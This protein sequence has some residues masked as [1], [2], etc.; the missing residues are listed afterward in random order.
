MR[1]YGQTASP[2]PAAVADPSPAALA[3]L[4]AGAVVAAALAIR[5]ALVARLCGL[6]PLPLHRRLLA[7]L[8][9]RS[10]R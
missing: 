6:R 3:V 7:E 8:G 1:R 10:R 2:L 4:G 9:H 5:P